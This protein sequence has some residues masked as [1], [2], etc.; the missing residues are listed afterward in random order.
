MDGK[1]PAP[2][3]QDDETQNDE[4]D[5]AGEESFPASDPPANTPVVGDRMAEREAAR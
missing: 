2:K 4:L 1:R 5:E 3:T